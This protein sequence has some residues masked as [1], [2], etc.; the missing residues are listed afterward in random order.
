MT[1]VFFMSTRMLEKTRRCCYVTYLCV[2]SVNFLGAGHTHDEQELLEFLVCPLG[3]AL[4]E[5]QD[6]SLFL[7]TEKFPVASTFDFQPILGL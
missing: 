3:V 2:V 6:S 7:K 1:K 4:L 5:N